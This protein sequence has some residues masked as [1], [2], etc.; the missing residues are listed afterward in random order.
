MCRLWERIKFMTTLNQI[1][2]DGIEEFRNLFFYEKDSE[3]EI[4]DKDAMVLF[5][6]TFAEKI[7]KEAREE[8]I[9]EVEKELEHWKDNYQNWKTRMGSSDLT[10]AT[11]KVEAL[12]DLLKALKEK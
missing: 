8:V 10:E 5:I 3:D 2:E 7:W 4:S 11:L 1:I 6:H 12:A 9:K